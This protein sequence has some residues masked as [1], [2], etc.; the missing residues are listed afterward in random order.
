MAFMARSFSDTVN[1]QNV[2]WASMSSFPPRNPGALD[3]T[4]T[5]KGLPQKHR[6]ISQRSHPKASTPRILSVRLAPFLDFLKMEAD[7]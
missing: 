5:N 1:V 6:N 3:L 7:S 4:L 2:R